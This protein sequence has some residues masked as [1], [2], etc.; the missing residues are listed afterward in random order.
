[1]FIGLNYMSIYYN[2]M[3]IRTMFDLCYHRC[4]K[5]EITRIPQYNFRPKTKKNNR[6]VM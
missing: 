3:L 2:R 1:M 4:V 6:N 5:G